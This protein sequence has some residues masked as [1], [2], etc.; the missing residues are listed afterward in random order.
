MIS[1]VA[2]AQPPAPSTLSVEGETTSSRSSVVES[3]AQS[4]KTDISPLDL[5]TESINGAQSLEK[6]EMNPRS[7]THYPVGS[8]T[9]A[10]PIAARPVPVLPGTVL[11]AMRNVLP[12]TSE[13]VA[14]VAT[15][16]T[17]VNPVSMETDLESKASSNLSNSSKN[18][19]WVYA[20]LDGRFHKRECRLAREALPLSRTEALAKE[21]KP[22]PVCRP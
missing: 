5:K 17:S 20:T 11:P 9:S 1:T 19:V 12:R 14:A 4:D 3:L 7:A 13:D 21:L 10:H 22:C 2:C 8:T 18:R 15:P 6:N 16:L